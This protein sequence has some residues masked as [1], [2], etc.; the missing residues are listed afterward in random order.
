ME[1]A[2]GATRPVASPAW[3]EEDATLAP[4]LDFI[5]PAGLAL[6]FLCLGLVALVRRRDG[7]V[8]VLAVLA[9][10]AMG[11]ALS[12][13]TVDDAFISLRYARNLASGDGL[14]FSTDGS[15]P[16]EG[17]SNFL[18]ILLE[19]P[20]FLAGL[21]DA[22]ALLGAKALGL[23]LGVGALLATA[24]FAREASGDPRVGATAA[25]A[26]A[27]IPFFAFWSV[28]G[29]ETPLYLAF[30]LAGA[31]A[32]LRETRLARPRAWSYVL[33][34][35]LALTRHEGLLVLVAALAGDLLLPQE[36]PARDRLARLARA[37]GA[38]AALAAFA[39]YFAWRTWY[40]ADLLPNVVRAKSALA[41]DANVL[42][43]AYGLIPFVSYLLPLLAFVVVWLLA[44]RPARRRLV[45]PAGLALLVLLSALSIR[46]E[47][48]P[49]FRYE[50]PF[51]AI[52]V[53]LGAWALHDLAPPSPRAVLP[54]LLAF[55]YLASP[56]VPLEDAR[57][58]GG[59][60][61][62]SHIAL[63]LWLREHA[64][65]D[66][67]FA[68]WDMGAIPY[69]SRLPTI[70]DIH[71]EGLV[72]AATTREGYDPARVLAQRPAFLVLPTRAENRSDGMQ[73]FYSEPALEAEYVEIFA[74]AYRPDDV[75]HLFV[76]RDVPLTDEALD[77]G[78]RISEES[79]RGLAAR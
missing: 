14:T 68:G 15:P 43:R 51:L 10:L 19:T 28:G 77:E 49:G 5:A 72:S 35:G 45:L 62:R 36:I 67:S 58:L 50:L 69:F 59:D 73:A 55:L 42:A 54:L 4:G 26:F 7:W 74:L 13:Y 40:Y 29:L 48:M 8:L 41:G 61:G 79:F 71:P 32:R 21:D 33:F 18:F 38:M 56:A 22:S 60:L 24:A 12:R 70:H 3:A 46:R 64:P 23:A 63:G 1:G 6:A 47:W 9:F 37:P 25:L 27:A 2:W 57:E 52:L 20:L 78:R 76:R 39:A 53:A 34:V 44:A 11:V 66:A 17:Y 31:A 75:L 30:L 65:A 16:V